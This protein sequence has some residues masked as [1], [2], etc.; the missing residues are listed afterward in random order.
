MSPLEFLREECQNVKTALEETL[1]YEY[2]P[3]Q[4]YAFYDE[5]AVRLGE[6]QRGAT[7]LSEQDLE[8]IKGLLGA[9]SYVS[10]LVSLIERSRLGEF[11]WPFVEELRR[12][13]G[14]L[15]S[16]NDFLGG[17]R[18]PLIHVVADG[19]SYLIHTEDAVQAAI[20]KRKFAIVLFPRPAKYLVLMHAIFGHEIGHA[21]LQTELTGFLLKSQLDAA[22]EADK[23]MNEAT[24]TAWLNDA[25]APAEVKR[26]LS[27]YERDHGKKYSFQADTL[28]AW[29]RELSCDLIGLLLFGPAFLA[30]HQSIIR[31]RH[32][33]PFRFE[34]SGSTHPPYA[35]RC[36]MLVRAL[37]LLK[38]HKTITLLKDGDFHDSEQ[39]F[40]NEINSD[41]YPSW[42]EVYQDS[43]LENAVAVIKIVLDAY[44][45]KPPELE[46]LLE[47]LTR[48][49][50]CLP[51]SQDFIDATGEAHIERT[52]FRQI[53]H[54]GWIFAARPS[55]P[56]ERLSF[57]QVL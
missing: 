16:E 46:T 27:D 37:R 41:S 33:N 26:F 56:D 7:Q 12:F 57:V 39:K 38:W 43:E 13:A 52:D 42:V 36:R 3:E 51:P 54:A 5:C 14:P 30:A 45:Y 47:L 24:V 21:T 49:R 50:S 32:P 2:G 4:S 31:P 11:S 53:L 55:V 19:Q 17:T 28:Q 9:L 44:I 34:S 1:R 10:F 15:L 8:L 20:G 18:E 23:L 25:S 40:I 6:I 29:R 35:V 22:L 48:L